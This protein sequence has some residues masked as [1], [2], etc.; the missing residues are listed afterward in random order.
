M[1]PDRQWA[2]IETNILIAANGKSDQAND[3]CMD[4]CIETLLEVRATA[5]LALDDAG[6]ILDEYSVYCSYSGQPGVGDEFFIWAHNNQYATCR[7]VRLTPHDDR[8]YQEFPDAPG[9]AKFDRSDRKWIA[10][11]LGCDPTATIYNAVDSDYAEA[12][13]ALAD[14]AIPVTE[15]CPDCLKPKTA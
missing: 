12:T 5:C 9:L 10:T 14:A 4:K 15:L 13:Q 7:R 3:A 6:E 8:V 2:V 11:A 1:T